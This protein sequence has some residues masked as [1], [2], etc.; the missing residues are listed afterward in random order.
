MREQAARGEC[1]AGRLQPHAAAFLAD[2][3]CVD[4]PRWPGHSRSAN[5]HRILCELYAKLP[6]VTIQHWL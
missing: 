2:G 1:R 4:W 5:P 6:G 3:A